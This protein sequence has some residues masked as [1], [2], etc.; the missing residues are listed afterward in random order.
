MLY[1]ITA[2]WDVPLYPIKGQTSDSFAYGAA[3]NYRND[4]RQIAIYYVG[5]HD[6]HGYE[7]ES[8]LRAKLLEHSE[9]TDIS[10]ARL[11]CDAE[12][13]E[14]FGLSGGK[15][16][17]NNYIDAMTGERVPWHGPAIEVEA[18]EPPYL[19]GVLEKVIVG[20]LDQEALRLTRI[21]E[22][23]ERSILTE[24]ANLGWDGA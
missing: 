20:H 12:D 4:P 11:A 13:V 10:W 15:P 17:K 2:K 24:I 22:E 23:S 6:P 14:H 5:D 1:P 19:R 9:R 16:K 8:N 21:A 18:L 7:I 3:Q